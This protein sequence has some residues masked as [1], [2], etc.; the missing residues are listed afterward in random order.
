[1]ITNNDFFYTLTMIDPCVT[2]QVNAAL[3]YDSAGTEYTAWVDT[4]LSTT[5]RLGVA[6]IYTYHRFMDST[7]ARHGLKT[8]SVL[9]LGADV[10]AG[11]RVYTLTELGSGNDYTTFTDNNHLVPPTQWIS[12]DAV[13]GVI[14]IKTDDFTNLH[15]NGNNQI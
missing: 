13:N 12:Y 3:Q 4:T 8:A 1:M 5:V 10:C 11:R 6:Q 15:W 14:S 2:S 9:D 7:S